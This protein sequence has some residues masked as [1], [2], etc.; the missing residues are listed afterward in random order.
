V[1]YEDD[2]WGDDSATELPP[3]NVNKKEQ[4]SAFY[5]DFLKLK[6]LALSAKTKKP[7]LNKAFLNHYAPQ[8]VYLSLPEVAPYL[9][10]YKTPI[11]Y[12]EDGDPIFP[13]NPLQ[14]ILEYRGLSKLGNTYLESINE[15]VENKKGDCIEGRVRASFHLS[16]CDTGRLS[17]SSPNFQN[18]PSGRS[19]MAKEVKN[20]FQA[21]GP[22]K[23]FPDGT[24]LIQ[25]DYKTAEVR[26]AAIFANDKNL[27]QLFNDAHKSLI[28]ACAP[29]AV[30]TEEEFAQT[31]LESDIHRRTASLMYGVEPVAVSKAQRQAS[32]S[33]SF[34]LLFGMSTETLAKNNGW[35]SEDA[36]E[37]VHKFFSAFPDLKR[38]LE[39]APKRAKA[40][41]YTETFMGRRRR[42]AFLF[43]TKRFSDEAL[44]GRLSM[45]APIQGQSSDGGIIGLITFLQFLL[46]HNL[47]RRWLIQNVVHDSVLVQV[48]M[49]DVE[50]ALMT[51]QYYFVQGMADYIYKHFGFKLPLPIECE[52]EVGL[53]YGA[54]TKWDGRP[55]TLPALIEN[56]K[57]DA[58]EL[59]YVK[60]EKTGKPIKEMDLVKWQGY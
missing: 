52:I 1:A 58:Q 13:K 45:N 27:I 43:A 30:M 59:W 7:T 15:M 2:I 29:D 31:Q 60:K 9:E 41:G 32:K 10:Y 53:K 57:K 24:A 11:D 34:G 12:E 42:L 35:T 46:D 38:Y 44:A 18:L 6:P 16:G 54:L 25:L 22:S 50:K 55:S 3:F 14:L 19:P 5:L 40:Q 39:G 26:W 20:L 51:M 8:D 36:E 48:P 28:K 17:S 21:E 37:K 4:E 56:L 33:I 47:E 23:K 49:L